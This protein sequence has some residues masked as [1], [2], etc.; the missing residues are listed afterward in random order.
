MSAIAKI[1]VPSGQTLTIVPV[2]VTSERKK[3]TD[4]IGEGTFEFAYDTG[5]RVLDLRKSSQ[6]RLQQQQHIA[7]LQAYFEVWLLLYYIFTT[8]PGTQM[9]DLQFPDVR[10]LDAQQS[11][12]ILAFVLVQE[13]R[14][15]PQMFC[16]RSVFFQISL[17]PSG[18]YE[19]WLGSY[20]TNAIFPSYDDN[21]SSEQG[22]DPWRPPN[23]HAS[24]RIYSRYVPSLNKMFSV[25][26]LS[27]EDDADTFSEWM[28]NDRVAEFWNMKG[29]KDSVHLSYLNTLDG[30]KH[31]V[32]VIGSLDQ[33]QFL[34]AELYYV[35]EDRLAPFADGAGPYDRGFHLLVGNERLRGPH[36]VR[37][38]LTS[39]VHCLFLQDP[40]T[41]YIFLEPRADNEKLIGYLLQYGFEKLKEFDFPH[42]RA[43]LVRIDRDT[44]F[45]IGPAQ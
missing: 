4:D 38:W 1:R 10:E 20:F 42:K 33:E 6:K 2:D 5:K 8:D 3:L 19:C 43:A 18:P 23:P 24:E 26:A 34:Y 40:R 22:R 35:K 30:D 36:I 39:I 25:R 13:D 9:I 41:Q 44:F 12:L 17:P 32:T 45:K 31:V 37:A 28:N 29:D 27:I 21:T 11:A 16:S 7:Q 15:A 14:H